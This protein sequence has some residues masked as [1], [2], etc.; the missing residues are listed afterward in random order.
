MAAKIKK[1]MG[2]DILGT[3]DIKENNGIFIEVQD[4]DKPMN[5]ADLIKDFNGLE[6]KIS[7]AQSEEI[8]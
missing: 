3:I 4:I 6:V 1:K 2:I 8:A 7:L 5:L